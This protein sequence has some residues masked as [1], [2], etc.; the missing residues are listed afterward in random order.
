MYSC[1]D[2]LMERGNVNL[3]QQP[4]VILKGKIKSND[5]DDVRRNEVKYQYG[6]QS[7]SD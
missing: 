3:E 4:P 7:E 5:E 6:D 1:N 2:Y